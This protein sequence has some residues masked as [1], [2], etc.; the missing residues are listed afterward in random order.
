MYISLFRLLVLCV[1]KLFF[2]NYACISPQ[3]L[4][5]LGLKELSQI[6]ALSFRVKGKAFNFINSILVAPSLK[7]M[8]T[9]SS[10]LMCV[11]GFSFSYHGKLGV[12]AP[13]KA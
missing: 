12:G 5:V 2:K 4:I 8:Q 11:Y 10:S 6:L 1:L 13:D 3:F 9:S 7:V